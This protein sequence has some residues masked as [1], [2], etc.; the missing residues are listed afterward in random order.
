MMNRGLQDGDFS[1]DATPE[2]HHRPIRG[3]EFSQSNTTGSE[4]RDDAF[5]K[6]ASFAA[7]GPSEERAGF[8]PGQHSPQPNATPRLPRRPHGRGNQVAPRHGLYP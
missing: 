2:R 4:S 6:G 3:S 8:H 1:K 7:T 5:K